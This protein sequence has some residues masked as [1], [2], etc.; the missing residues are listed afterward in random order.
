MRNQIEAEIKGLLTTKIIGQ[1]CVCLEETDS[2]NT[3]AQRLAKEGAPHGTLVTADSQSA[4]KGRRGRTWI[5]QA[6]DHIYMSLLLRPDIQPDKASMLTLVMGLSAAGACQ[7]LLEEAGSRER[8]GIKW[9]NDLVWNGRKICGILTE[10]Q[11]VAEGIDHVVVGVGINVN[12]TRFPAELADTAA[13]LC[14]A[15]GHPLP[16]PELIARVLNRFER[17]Y[18]RFLATEDLSG[19]QADYESFLVN[20]GRQVRVLDSIDEYTGI[21]RGINSRGELLVECDGQLHAVYAGEVSVRGVYG[22]I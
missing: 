4:G 1:N 14:M 6:E 13:S 8:V 5:S 22:Y 15:A 17:D 2:T 11:T 10:M 7:E 3:Q 16:R 18:E 19:L 21:A 20:C 9:P 12:G